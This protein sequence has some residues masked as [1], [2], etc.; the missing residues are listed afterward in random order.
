MTGGLIGIRCAAVLFAL[1]AGYTI[2][3]VILA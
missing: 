1:P 2:I 3:G